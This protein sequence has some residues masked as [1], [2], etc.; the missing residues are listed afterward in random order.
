MVQKSQEQARRRRDL[1]KIHIARKQ[2]LGM[3]EDQYRDLL[4]D[5]FGVD[6]AADLDARQ[7]WTLIKRM[8]ALG[9]RFGR[10]ANAVDRQG[11]KI[12]ALWQALH[13]AGV[14]RDGS[15]RALD[16][17]VQRQ[18]KVATLRWLSPAQA[19][20]VIEAL[21]KWMQREGVEHG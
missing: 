1:A 13:D 17:Y 2:E 14:V 6:S 10:K 19:T 12:K 11:A 15:A 16:G 18:T 5:M 3:S 21:K 7:R 8:E 9:V 4:R 20:Q